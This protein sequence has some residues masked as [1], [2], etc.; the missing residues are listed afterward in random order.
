MRREDRWLWMGLGVLALVLLAGPMLGGGMG[1]LGGRGMMGWY[2]AVGPANGW[3]WG[4]GMGIGW[5]VML[6]FWAAVIGLVVLAVRRMTSGSAGESPID[7]LERRYAAGEITRE[8]YQEMREVL[9]GA[10]P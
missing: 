2:G 4:L 8:Q 7:I 10:R 9:E 1:M 6:A 3:L 5:L